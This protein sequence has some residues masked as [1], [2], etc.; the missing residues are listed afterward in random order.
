MEFEISANLGFNY[1]IKDSPDILN[2]ENKDIATYSSTGN[3]N[4]NRRVVVIDR[5]VNIIYG[6]RIRNY[7]D[8]HKLNTLFVILE[9][10]ED[11]KI[12][13]SLFLLLNEIEQFGI[14][15]RDEPIIAIGGGVIMDIVGLAAALY[16]R[17]IPYL[18]IPTTLLGIVDVS[19]AAKTGINYLDRR[20]RL[21]SYYPPVAS[22]LD[23]S[24]IQ[25]QEPIEISSGLGEILKIAVIKDA[26]LFDIIEKSGHELLET[27][28]NCENSSEVIHRSVLA[29][30]EE[31]ENNLWEKNL[32]RC[33]DFGHSFSPMIEMRLL[34]TD[35]PIT[36]GQAV[37]LDVIFSS[38]I[39][40]IRGFLKIEDVKRIISTASK[41]GLMTAHP[42]FERF[43]L[44]WAGLIDTKKHRGGNQNLPIPTNIGFYTFINDLRAVETCDAIDLLKQL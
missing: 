16:R 4:S 43:D 42:Y 34:E 17:G 14:S 39:S 25:T 3:G 30:K 27:K 18:R 12:L 29:M 13:E 40:H 6:D 44:L 5:K 28:F 35:A 11:R 38:V 24:F 15:R 19:V 37:T 7:F 31:L 2:P 41:M 8:H 32:K 20:N 33:V 36:H 26:G 22:L 10:T 1:I 21:G 23:K 9:G